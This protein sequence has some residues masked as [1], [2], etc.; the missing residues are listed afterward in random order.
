MLAQMLY[1]MSV[2]PLDEDGN[3]QLCELF[4]FKKTKVSSG[5]IKNFSLVVQKPFEAKQVS[6]LIVLL[7]VYVHYGVQIIL[8]FSGLRV[9]TEAGSLSPKVSYYF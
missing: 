5:G 6:E 1:K 9:F 7:L 3:D 2:Q 8:F 4:I